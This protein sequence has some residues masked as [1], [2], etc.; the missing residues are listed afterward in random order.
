MDQVFISLANIIK[1]ITQISRKFFPKKFFKTRIRFQI[2]IKNGTF[3]RQYLSQ[4]KCKGCL[5]T[6]AQRRKN[7]DDLHCLFQHRKSYRIKR[8]LFSIAGHHL[9]YHFFSHCFIGNQQQ[10]NMIFFSVGNETF[11]RGKCLDLKRK[12]LF[13]VQIIHK[14]E[15][16]IHLQITDCKYVFLQYTP[17]A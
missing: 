2:Q 14:I 3:F 10:L 12:I 4:R 6:S 5:Q 1:Q 9:P 17:P 7:T 16:I 11:C 8:L 13:L 15:S